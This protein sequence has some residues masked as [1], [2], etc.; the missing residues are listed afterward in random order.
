MNKYTIYI[1]TYNILIS[2]N[3]GPITSVTNALLNGWKIIIIKQRKTFLPN[4]NR[5]KSLRPRRA[6]NACHNQSSLNNRLFVVNNGSVSRVFYFALCECHR[7][8]ENRSGVIAFEVVGPQTVDVAR[9]EKLKCWFS[10]A[11]E[12]WRLSGR[13]AVKARS[14]TRRVAKRL[15]QQGNLTDTRW[16]YQFSHWALKRRKIL[17]KL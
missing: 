13:V 7:V 1:D 6:L 12:V 10:I 11:S 5:Y 15:A 8:L 3:F 2:Y 4:R 9:G 14:V 16:T 17:I